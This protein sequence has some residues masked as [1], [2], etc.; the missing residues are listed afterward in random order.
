MFE[1]LCCPIHKYTCIIY[2][3]KSMSLSKYLL[4]VYTK[5][6]EWCQG[7]N[8]QSIVLIHGS[9][10]LRVIHIFVSLTTS[11]SAK[12][13]K[14]IATKVLFLFCFWRQAGLKCMIFLFQPP[15]C[16]GCRQVPL[17]SSYDKDV[18]L[19]LSVPPS[20]PSGCPGPHYVDWT[21]RDPPVTTSPV[22]GSKACVTTAN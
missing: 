2:E 14:R 21:H 16:W 3:A 1:F 11:H 10:S 17:Q 9:C 7:K 15:K 18:F 19:P 12:K 6:Y 20:F 13:K 4:F 22:L 8:Q 5:H